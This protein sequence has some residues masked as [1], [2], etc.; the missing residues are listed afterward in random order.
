ML[1][2]DLLGTRKATLGDVPALSRALAAAFFGDPVFGWAIPDDR[3]RR[4]ILPGFFRLIS[5]ATVPHG[6]VY[7]IDTVVSGAIWVPPGT[8]GESE[9]LARGLAEITA[10]CAQRFFQLVEAMREKHPLERHYYLFFLGTRP[11][12]QSRGLGSTLMRPVLEMCDR[13]GMPA[14]LEATSEG[15]KRLYLRH[16]FQVTGRLDLPDGP[17]MWCMWR[18]PQATHAMSDRSA[19]R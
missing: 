9:Q 12:W 10:E 7:T 3:R 18:K 5:E 16:G 6:E 13:G 14:Y 17:T 1:T 19:T 2:P 8:E 11:E 4:E 15:N